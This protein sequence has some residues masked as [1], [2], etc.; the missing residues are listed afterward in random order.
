MNENSD[1]KRVGFDPFWERYLAGEIKPQISMIT[2]VVKEKIAPLFEQAEKEASKVEEEF[3]YRPC[4]SDSFDAGDLA[5]IALEAGLERFELVTNITY[6]I[7]NMFAVSLYHLFEQ[8]LFYMHQREFADFNSEK[9]SCN[10]PE[11]KTA[12]SDLGISIEA[13][14]TY[15][16]IEELRFLCNCIKH[17]EGQ[18]CVKVRQLRTDFFSHPSVR[19]WD[20]VTVDY[21]V[22][23]FNPISGSDLWVTEKDLEGY[24]QAVIDFFQKLFRTNHQVR[25]GAGLASPANR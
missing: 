13:F 23:V 22:P 16:K 1:K 24:A 2:R 3:W 17:G 18:S 25:E 6:G 4:C 8:H 21:P 20:T 12:L 5:E 14:G 15:P 19:D 9:K 7:L 10:M 11:V